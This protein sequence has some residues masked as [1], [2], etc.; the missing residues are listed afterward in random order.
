MNV[1]RRLWVVAVSTFAAYIVGII[2]EFFRPALN[3]ATE[4]TVLSPWFS[5]GIP[6]Y[7]MSW[8]FAIAGCIAA[9]VAVGM[10]A[11]PIAK[12]A[13]RGAEP[14][15][16]GVAKPVKAAGKAQP[17]VQAGDVPGM[18]GFDFEQAKAEIK[19]TPGASPHS[20]APPAQYG[21]RPM[22]TETLPAALDQPGAAAS[23]AIV[24]PPREPQP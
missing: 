7:V 1:F 24:E 10:A 9:A 16:A 19:S 3:S 17:Q 8:L 23:G 11:P 5:T 13:Q 6:Q 21:S 12:R 18:P 14:G 15:A 20:S 2:Y 22:L 4:N